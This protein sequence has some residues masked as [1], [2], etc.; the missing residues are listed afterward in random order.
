MKN[1]QKYSEEDYDRLGFP[2]DYESI[3]H[4][5]RSAYAKENEVTLTPLDG[6]YT[7]KIGHREKM[8]EIDIKKLN[9][10]YDCQR[11]FDDLRDKFH[12]KTN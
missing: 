11:Y 6:R 2:Y 8:S 7:D 3:I 12:G 4:Y 9:K 1:F 10:V 5:K